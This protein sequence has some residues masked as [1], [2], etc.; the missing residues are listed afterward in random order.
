MAKIVFF[1]RSDGYQDNVRGKTEKI[2][3]MKNIYRV[4]GPIAVPHP[5]IP[6]QSAGV[7]H[8][9]ANLEKWLSFDNA[10]RELLERVVSDNFS[11]STY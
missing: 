11:P 2:D 3:A 5:R 10:K 4:F 7:N 1:G 9:Y 6:G 8:Y